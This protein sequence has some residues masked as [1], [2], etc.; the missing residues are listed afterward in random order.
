MSRS[1]YCLE[2]GSF[3]YKS[4]ARMTYLDMVLYESMR[5]YP[6]TVGFITRQALNDYEVNGLKIPKGMNVLVPVSYL[7]HDPDVWHEPERFDPEREPG[8]ASNAT[9]YGCS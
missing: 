1:S 7:H 9:P 2:T 5:L 4:T 6:Q 8:A 3:T